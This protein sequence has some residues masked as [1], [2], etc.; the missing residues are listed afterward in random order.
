MYIAPGPARL[1]THYELRQATVCCRSI[2]AQVLSHQRAILLLQAAS[3][4]RVM[5]LNDL[6][7]AIIEDEGIPSIDAWRVSL[8]PNGAL[9]SDNLTLQG[10]RGKFYQAV[11]QTFLKYFLAVNWA[12]FKHVQI[13]TDP[14]LLSDL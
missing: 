5:F 9:H 2:F 1:A 7:D 14:E 11:T 4:E 3:Q 8:H 10:L 13:Y 6:A 12:K